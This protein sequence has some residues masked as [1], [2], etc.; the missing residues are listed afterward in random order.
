MLVPGGGGRHDRMSARGLDSTHS[1]APR[2]RLQFVVCTMAQLD[3]AQTVR[4]APAQRT[5][6]P[7]EPCIQ[8]LS[9]MDPAP[10]L[11]SP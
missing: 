9:G 2:Y 7:S 1:D 11:L 8:V 3:A 10:S 5:D 6:F 4:R